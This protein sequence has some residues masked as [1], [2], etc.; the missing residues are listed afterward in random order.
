MAKTVR[1][2]LADPEAL[3]FD[4]RIAPEILARLKA[5]TFPPLYYNARSGALKT[6]LSCHLPPYPGWSPVNADREGILDVQY[7]AVYVDLEKRQLH[8]A[9]ML[10][11]LKKR[12][13]SHCPTCKQEIPLV[14]RVRE[15]V[16]YKGALPLDADAKPLIGKP[17]AAARRAAW[18][19]DVELLSRAGARDP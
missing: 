6:T 10:R 17:L 16:V 13:R 14:R 5:L 4:C 1:G 19:S 8:F 2:A 3:L 9:E 12:T 11:E 15:R 18:W 7:I